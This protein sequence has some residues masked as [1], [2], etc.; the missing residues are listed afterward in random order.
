MG[1]FGKRKKRESDPY[2]RYTSR[3]FKKVTDDELDSEREKV[4]L[5]HCK[6]DE[7]AMRYLNVFDKEKRQ[8]YEKK[9][10]KQETGFPAHREHGWYLP[11]DD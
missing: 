1:L 6:G 2:E 10:G 8:R 3:F 7:R 5:R 4:R 11:N 9:H